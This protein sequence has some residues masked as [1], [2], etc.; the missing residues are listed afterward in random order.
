MELIVEERPA[1][2]T[3]R[4]NDD[5]VAVHVAFEEAELRQLLRKF[6]GKWDPERKQWFVTYGLI[7]G[8]PLEAR[9]VEG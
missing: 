8:T 9:I 5:I 3:R 4:R 2:N 7:R 6:R 1:G